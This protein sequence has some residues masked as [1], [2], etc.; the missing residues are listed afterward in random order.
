MTARLH[1]RRI[2]VDRALAGAL[3]PRDFGAVLEAALARSMAGGAPALGRHGRRGGAE[4]KG[5]Q[6]GQRALAERVA[7]ALHGSVPALSGAGKGG[8]GQR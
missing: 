1:I 8:G 4:A 5:G 7:E 3:D 2:V 6:G